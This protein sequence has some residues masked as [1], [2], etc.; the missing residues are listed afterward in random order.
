MIRYCS[1]EDVSRLHN[2][3]L[4]LNLRDFLEFREVKKEYVSYIVWEGNL[5]RVKKLNSIIPYF[6]GRG[7]SDGEVVI[8]N[9]KVHL[10]VTTS[11]NIRIWSEEFKQLRRF[12]K[13]IVIIY[14]ID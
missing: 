10:F 14:P 9:E 8:V 1:L 3:I 4:D 5:V 7:E 11:F 2:I 12:G 13:G 6:A